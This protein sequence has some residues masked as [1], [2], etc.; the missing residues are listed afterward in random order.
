MARDVKEAVLAYSIYRIAS[1][2]GKCYIGLTKQP[3]RERWRQH[4][5]RA[6]AEHRNHPFYNAIRKYGPENFCIE[7]IDTAV[8]K[9]EAQQ[10]ERYW[11]ARCPEEL[12]YNISPG[13]EADGEA[14]AAA[15]WGAI[16]EDPV[17]LSE[18]KAKLSRAKKGSDW[19]DYARL[20]QL[21]AE[22]RKQHPKEAYRIAYRASRIAA[23]LK[24]QP[25]T[26]EEKDRKDRLRWRYKRSDA[27][28]E[29]AEKQ[30]DARTDQQRAELADKIAGS[31]RGYWAGIE[32]PVE[33]SRK[34]EAARAAIDREK[35]GAAASRGLKAFW[36][37]LKK[38]PERYRDYIE[39]RKAS[40]H[41][42]LQRKNGQ[43]L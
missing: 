30:W 12:R 43:N 27:A 29:Q 23:G 42:T 8:S 2:S 36:V 13:G 15:F 3:V 11:I 9:Q 6:V 18:Y 10:K 37:E 16:K 5:R 34:T 28:R 24:K 25:A 4:K 17:R 33:R 26:T 22:W 21:S 32:D 7:T 40:L 41:D 38:D 39:R 20:A 35:Q 1:P 14:G 19:S 31:M